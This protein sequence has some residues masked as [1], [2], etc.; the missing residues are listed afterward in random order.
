M[1]QFRICEFSSDLFGGFKYNLDTNEVD[2]IEEIIALAV[3]RLRTTLQTSN[4]EIL[5]EK[6]D[7]TKW[8]IHSHT[9]EDVLL[10]DNDTIWICDHCTQDNAME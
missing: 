3:Y 4:F 2:S 5:V 1:S 6:V 9:F 10:K 7:K 8:H